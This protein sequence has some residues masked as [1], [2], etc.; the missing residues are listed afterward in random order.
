[1]NPAAGHFT[2]L[3]PFKEDACPVILAEEKVINARPPLIRVSIQ[4]FLP[5]KLQPVGNTL[6]LCQTKI[7]LVLGAAYAATEAWYEGFYWPLPLNKAKTCHTTRR[8]N[9]HRG[10]IYSL[11]GADFVA[12]STNPNPF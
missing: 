12:I 7:D 3:V 11:A 1:M 10:R 8:P 5:D 9:W 6:P 2:T 4:E